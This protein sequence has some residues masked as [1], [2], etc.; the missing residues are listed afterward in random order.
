VTHVRAVVAPSLNALASIVPTKLSLTR[1][2]DARG[3]K[4]FKLIR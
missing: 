1:R 2:D 3:Q 4:L